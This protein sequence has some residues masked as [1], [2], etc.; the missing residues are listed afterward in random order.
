MTESMTD[1]KTE[2]T[3]GA[4]DARTKTANP[5]SANVD[6]A[7]VSSDLETPVH[8][9]ETTQAGRGDA[10]TQRPTSQGQEAAKKVV[11]GISRAAQGAGRLTA[12]VVM[13]RRV[14]GLLSTAPYVLRGAG[15]AVAIAAFLFPLVQFGLPGF[16]G[17]LAD[18]L[19]NLLLAYLLFIGADAAATLNTL[20]DRSTNH[21]TAEE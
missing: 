4:A 6:A 7:T 21:S 18:A 2:S 10:A 19:A 9:T 11:S 12:D 5:A 17:W 8:V 20:V 3:S 13:G 1:S 16:A 15:L 14:T